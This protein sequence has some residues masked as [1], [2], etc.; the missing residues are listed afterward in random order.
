MRN[1]MQKLSSHRQIGYTRA[2]RA[3]L[4]L[5]MLLLCSCEGRSAMSLPLAGIFGLGGNNEEDATN[6]RRPPPQTGQGPPPR[7]GRQPPPQSRGQG[8]PLQGNRPPTPQHGRGPPPQ[9][10]RGTPPPRDERVT[11]PQGQPQ[12][13]PPFM[14]PQGM[15]PPQQAQPRQH[16]PPIQNQQGR[17]FPARPEQPPPPPPV[18]EN[19][20]N[21][22]SQ[23]KDPIAEDADAVEEAELV[24][25]ASVDGSLDGDSVNETINE[26]NVEIR[27]QEEPGGL[28]GMQETPPSRDL[29]TTV[30]Q[31]MPPLHD[32]PR[33]WMDQP[34]QS[35][36]NGWAAPPPDFQQ[37]GWLHQHVYSVPPGMQGPPM[38]I[39]EE[40]DMS[41][42]REHDLLLQ[43]NNLT[44]MAT[45][46][47]QREEIHMRQLDVLTERV[48][49]VESQAAGDRNLLLEYEANCTAL[50]MTIATL[51]DELEEWQKRC[52]DLK[53]QREQDE[54]LVSEM[55][56]TIKE[57]SSEAEEL[58]IAIEN[59]RLV[60]RV[61]GA[62]NSRRKQGKRG[63]FSWVLGFF[64]SNDSDYEE[65]TRE[66]CAHELEW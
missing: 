50:G 66:V 1:N 45:N 51:Q 33:G 62:S 56:Q 28:A 32:S 55:K 3:L 61:K 21:V 48:M 23:A 35:N 46:Y 18:L 20:E 13:R 39:Q 52:A 30:E 59:L 42:A 53:D 65:V 11:P 9:G 43:V 16:P 44:E 47:R 40:L 6:S 63:F 19:S 58:A 54:E 60:E 36:Y 31:Q 41:L 27:E 37:G 24:A 7:E 8:P 38:M 29:E 25:S 22:S 14:P 10:G 17:Q 57:K 5:W 49:E 64:L 12:R 15:P 26:S 34:P 2:L 4:V